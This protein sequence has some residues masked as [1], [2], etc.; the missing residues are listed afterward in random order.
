MEV[1]KGLRFRYKVKDDK[2]MVTGT[3]TG[4][5]KATVIEA[6]W[7]LVELEGVGVLF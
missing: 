5:S 2:I 7:N 1:P 6:W 3:K 4:I